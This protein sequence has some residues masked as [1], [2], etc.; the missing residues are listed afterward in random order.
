MKSFPRVAATITAVIGALVLVGRAF[1]VPVLNSVLRGHSTVFSAIV[2]AALLSLSVQSLFKTDVDRRRAG[3]ALQRSEERYRSLVTATSAVVWTA[4]ARG[5]FTSPQSS[6]EAYTGQPWDKHQGWGW[7]QMIHPDDRE[8]V[9]GLWARSLAE[10][11]HYQAEGRLWH[12]GLR[13]YRHFVARAV[14]IPGPGG[15]VREWIGAITDVDDRTRAEAALRDS[16]ERLSQALKASRVGTWEWLVTTNGIA[17]HDQTCALFGL[18][19]GRPPTGIDAVLDRVHP[20]DRERVQGE[21]SRSV[22]AGAEYDTEFR[23]VWPDGSIRFL[24]ARGKVYRDED[25]RPV[26]MLGVNWDITESKR[27]GDAL[28]RHAAELER[29]N[30]ELQEFASVASHDLQEPLRKIVAFGDRLGSRLGTGLD[31][32]ARDYLHRMQGAARRMSN[33]IDSLLQLSRVTTRARP[34]Q[35]TDLS[36]VVSEVLADLDVT[37]KETRARVEVGP[38]PRIA[39]DRDQIRRLFQNLIANALKFRDPRKEP[40]IAVKSDPNGNGVCRITIADNGLGFD[41]KHAERLFKPFQRLHG[42]GEFEGDGM[43]LSICRRIVARHGGQITA[44]S[45]LGEGS[46]FV[47]TLPARQPVER[48]T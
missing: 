29:S 33:L 28:A 1:D 25:G 4:D 19:P 16:E 3:E 27:A 20:D 48:R 10:R 21:I 7:A 6:W 12:A 8:R 36:A 41:E 26:R 44:R 45:T 17:W 37:I 22:E 13:E 2:L 46:A 30:Q 32:Q 24:V 23:G 47:V 43:G 5:A 15:A 35:P 39:A 9:K 34:F 11:A 14:P 42:R 38:L 18:E 40:V 31:E